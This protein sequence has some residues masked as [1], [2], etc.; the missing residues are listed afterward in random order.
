MSLWE[1]ILL[2]FC[3][4]LLVAYLL[5]MVRIIG[6]LLFGVHELSGWWKA[7]WFVAL[8]LL[9][10][11]TAF[12]YLIARSRGMGTSEP[13]TNTTAH[14]DATQHEWALAGRQDPA[15]QIARARALLD[16]GTITA[17]EFDRRKARALA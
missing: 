1:L 14:P 11:V 7:V 17:P 15:A 12:V 13:R 9:P 5:F 2:L 3:I 8:I 6:D 10:L 16:A 4:H